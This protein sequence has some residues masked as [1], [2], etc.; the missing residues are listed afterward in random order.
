MLLD[1]QARESGRKAK[2]LLKN[3]IIPIEFYGN[4]VDNLSL[5]VDYQVFRK[6]F[7][8]AGTNTVIEATV[9]GKDKM[10]VLV[11]RIDFHPVTDQIT[12]VEFINVKMDEEIHTQ[13]PLEFEGIAPAVKELGGTMTHNLEQ[14][15]VKCLPKDLV[16][17]LPVNVESIVDF[18]TSIR[19][20]DLTVP[21]TIAVLNGLED[22]V[23]SVSAPQAEE[24]EEVVEEGV[25]GDSDESKAAEGKEEEAK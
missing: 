8:V 12:H 7:R 24:V 2:D 18:H 11:H 17:S 22:V 19:V 14:L 5:Q 4:G 21:S 25:E 6:L 23:A 13:I 1:V 3:G 20:K 15:D 9:D 10:N 16:H